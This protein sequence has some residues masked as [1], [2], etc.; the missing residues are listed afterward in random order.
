MNIK[1]KTR[2]QS[3]TQTKRKTGKRITTSSRLNKGPHN[4]K[5][6]K[7]LKSIERT[8]SKTK[9]VSIVNRDEVEN[10]VELTYALNLVVAQKELG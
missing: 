5:Q 10:S 8:K 2:E 9:L 1:E 6:M 3:E 4:H 7:T